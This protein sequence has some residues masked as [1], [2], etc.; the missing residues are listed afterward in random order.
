MHVC[1]ANGLTEVRPFVTSVF[2]FSAAEIEQIRLCWVEEGKGK[3]LRGL[4]FLINA[5]VALGLE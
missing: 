2:I 3:C 5:I 1:R 4:M